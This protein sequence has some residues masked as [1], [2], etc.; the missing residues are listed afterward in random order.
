MKTPHQVVGQVQ[1]VDQSCRHEGGASGGNC[2][3]YKGEGNLK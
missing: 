1:G 2:R 3:V